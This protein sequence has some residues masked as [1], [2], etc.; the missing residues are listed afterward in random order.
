[1]LLLLV[2]VVG[3][4]PGALAHD[5][6]GNPSSPVTSNKHLELTGEGLALRLAS[7]RSFFLI[8]WSV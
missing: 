8:L 5:D 3:N 6:Q 4:V 7:V 2:F 1:M